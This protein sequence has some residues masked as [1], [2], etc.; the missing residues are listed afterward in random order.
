MGQSEFINDEL[1]LWKATVSITTQE[2]EMISVS[3]LVNTNVIS[4]MTIKKADLAQCLVV[5]RGL[6]SAH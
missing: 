6:R 2:L 3:L 1:D 4:V 5:L